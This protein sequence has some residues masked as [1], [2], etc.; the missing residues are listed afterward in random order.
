[1]IEKTNAFEELNA[2][3]AFSH[4]LY[5]SVPVAIW[6]EDWSEVLT[7]LGRLREKGVRNTRDY[8]EHHPLLAEEISKK[9]R[10]RT[11]NHCAVEMFR[12]QSVEELK[13]K[14][15]NIVDIM[16]PSSVFPAAFDAILQ[17]RR[18]IECVTRARRLDGQV[19]HVLSRMVLPDVEDT[20]GHV[21]I[22]ETDISAFHVMNERFR[23]AARIA[24]LGVWD[25]QVNA[26]E[27]HWSPVLKDMLGLPEDA[28][29]DLDLIRKRISQESRSAFDNLVNFKTRSADT[30]RLSHTLRYTRPDETNPR[31]FDV[32][33]WKYP[34]NEGAFSRVL[35]VVRDVTSEKKIDEQLF[36]AATHDLLTDLPNRSFVARQ[37]SEAVEEAEETGAQ[38]GLLVLDVDHFKLVNNTY[39]H[40]VGDALL[41]AFAARLRSILHEK[42]FTARLG[43]DEFAVLIPKAS[44]KGTL[45]AIA[46]RIQAGMAEPFEIEGIT[47]ECRPSIGGCQ[48]NN[49]SRTAHDMMKG[50]NL[51]L[52]AAK[53]HRRG[54][55][56]MFRS[57]MLAEV[58]KRRTDLNR[59]REA[60]T[61][62]RVEAYYQS[63]VDLETG[64]VTGLEALLRWRKGK[65]PYQSP[66][67]VRT[68]LEDKGTSAE[69]F[70]FMFSRALRDVQAWQERG[71]QFG[72]VAL[73]VGSAELRD[74]DFASRFLDKLAETNIQTDV[75]QLE[76][77]ESVFLDNDLDLVAQTI[78]TLGAAGLKIALDD[79]GTGYAALSHLQRYPINILKID[80]KFVQGVETCKGNRDIVTAILDLGRNFGL[81]VIAEGVE[82]EKQSAHLRAA[83]CRYGQGFL[84][85]RPCSASSITRMLAN[86]V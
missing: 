16:D 74:Q 75:F 21:L 38:P 26:E 35:A 10:I 5:D 52:D 73:N 12:A 60:L 36:R 19:M 40:D 69:I 86:T 70:D 62:K 17:G 63:K 51:A 48:L 37:I 55:F 67:S 49:R 85:S 43:G 11:A 77:L 47:I 1:M 30:K 42:Y 56:S 78:E 45:A 41:V 57:P 8:M 72:N 83:G 14:A 29:A 6:E 28:P 39:G 13:R 23:L 31:W 44:G 25:Y 20:N 15:R 68:A 4:M 66:E 58:R 7:I 79:F 59:L 61:D 54:S 46:K 64:R 33:A 2:E 3:A 53:K 81:D 84:F 80:K 82:T 32:D 22:C 65:G 24:H 9:I 18:E 71:L 76:V 34:D 27:H 50:A